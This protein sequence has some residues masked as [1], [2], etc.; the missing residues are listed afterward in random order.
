MIY[1]LCEVTYSYFRERFMTNR[2]SHQKREGIVP[3]KKS[4]Y[5]P[6]ED[7]EP[8]YCCVMCNTSPGIQ[9]VLCRSTYYCSTDCERS[10]FRS[11]S[12]LCEKFATQLDRPSPEHK[13]AIYF[14][15]EGEKPCLI[16]VPCRRQYDEDGI[17][18][19]QIDPYPYIG[20]D[21]P[22]E[23]VMR[24]EHNPVRYRN[25]GAG[26]AGYAPYKEG[27]CVSLVFR[28]AYLKDGSITNKSI[29]ASVSASCT[30]NISHE[31]RGPMIAIREVPHGDFTDITLADFRH[32]AD[33][34]VSYRN[35]YIRESVP[36]QLHRASTTVRGVKICC[37]GETK[38]HGSEPFVSVD[39]TRAN[40]ISLGSGSISP[41]SVCLGM[42]IRLWKDPDTEFRHDAPGWEGGMTADSNPNVAFLM[43]E[44]DASKDEW[45]CAPMYWNSEIGN[46]WAVREDGQDLAVNR[47]DVPFCQV[48][49]TAYV[50]RRDGIG[51]E[52]SE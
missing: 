6:L 47:K 13:R 52:L 8:Q 11:H 17:K 38:L 40:Q 46:V 35:T 22:L 21:K 34:L 18:W 1:C 25:L 5:R 14:P 45:G 43:R 15:T 23:G 33:Y 16:W 48:R 2:S 44:T 4:R 50:R 36:G 30:S 41:I 7:F 26:F 51:L 10:D 9:C 12:L 32:L 29:L 37:H 28:K 39:V 27:Y 3:S 49:T 42:A 24:I 19:T 31:Y 20:N